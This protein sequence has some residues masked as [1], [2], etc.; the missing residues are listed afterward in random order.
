M[1]LKYFLLH[2][3]HIIIIT[4][5][6]ASKIISVN[7]LDPGSLISLPTQFQQSKRKNR[8][9]RLIKYILKLIICT[10]LIESKL[11]YLLQHAGHLNVNSS[12][13]LRLLT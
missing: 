13:P 10:F 4:T 11:K 3:H 2:H 12:Y 8:M 5:F 9:K 1:T 6:I 7:Y